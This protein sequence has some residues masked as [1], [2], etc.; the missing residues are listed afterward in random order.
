[1]AWS[2]VKWNRYYQVE[3]MKR[4]CKYFILLFAV[5]VASCEKPEMKPADIELLP[6]AGYIRFSTEVATKAPMIESMR[7]RNF[8]V[9]GYEYGLNSSWEVAKA[10][11]TPQTFYN[12]EVSCANN[13]VCTY[14]LDISSSDLNLKRWELAKKYSFFAYYPLMKESNGT[15]ALSAQTAVNVPTVTYNLPFSSQPVNPNSLLD[16]MTAYSFDNTAG[17]GNVDFEFKHRLFCIEVLAQNFNTKNTIKNADGTTQEI[18]AYEYISNL[19]LT[20]DNLQYQ[21]LTVPMQKKEKEEETYLA[22]TPIANTNGAVTFS[23]L[24]GEEVIT[25]PPRSNNGIGEVSLC[26]PNNDRF[27]MLVP[28]NGEIKGKVSFTLKNHAEITE[29]KELPFEAN[30]SLE[31]GQKYNMTISFTGESVVIA[32]SEA[33]V[34]R[35]KAVNYE[36]E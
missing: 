35:A 31:E 12:Q 33:G 32:M 14:D 3:D 20:I 19:S 21:G 28:Q 27:L 30:M 15:I 26:G 9:L 2:T 16:L 11:A 10:L 24:S 25:V 23:L 17:A 5:A 7:G 29:T 22:T 34:W 4:L 13:G 8:G 1:M 18:D 6:E 36:F